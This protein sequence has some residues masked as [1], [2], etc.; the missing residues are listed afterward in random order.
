MSRKELKGLVGNTY[1]N[2]G[3][4]LVGERVVAQAR[5]VTK[6]YPVP[7]TSTHKI[8]ELILKRNVLCVIDRPF[9]LVGGAMQ[10]KEIPFK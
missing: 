9:Q 10:I 7:G 6:P 4:A 2:H 3:D 1:R 8:Q 5:D